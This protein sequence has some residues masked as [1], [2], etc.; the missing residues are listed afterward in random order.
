MKYFIRYILLPF[1]VLFLAGCSW[2][3]TTPSELMSISLT[4]GEAAGGDPITVIIQQPVEQNDFVGATYSTVMQQALNKGV[5]RYVMLATQKQHTIVMP[6]TQTPLAVYFI[7]KHQPVSNWKFLI[8]E[9][10]ASSQFFTINKNS[11]VKETKDE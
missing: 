2:M 3:S 4:R 11:V 5:T 10:Q 1:I 7:M 6:V 8:D 9:P